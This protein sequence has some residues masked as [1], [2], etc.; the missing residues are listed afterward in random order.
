LAAVA[1][2]FSSVD[3]QTRAIGPP[4]SA[5]AHAIGSPTGAV[6]PVKAPDRSHDRQ[7]VPMAPCVPPKVMKTPERSAD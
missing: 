4:D 5:L 1:S 6:G 3:S 2:H 7:G